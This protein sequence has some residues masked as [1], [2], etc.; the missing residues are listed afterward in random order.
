MAAHKQCDDNNCTTAGSLVKLKLSSSS[1][2]SPVGCVTNLV[3]MMA[4]LLLTTMMGEELLLDKATDEGLGR[5][6]LG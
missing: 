6:L 4:P 3:V 5:I 1:H 2:H